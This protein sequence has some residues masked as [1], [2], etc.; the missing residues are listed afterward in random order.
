[1]G[2]IG[3]GAQWARRGGWAQWGSTRRR[4]TMGT[5]GGAQWVLGGGALN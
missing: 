4:G 3:G 2:V 5:G 1:M